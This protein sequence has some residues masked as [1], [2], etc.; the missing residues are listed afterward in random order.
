ML[1]ELAAH[2]GRALPE[3][4]ALP[5]LRSNGSLAQALLGVRNE[6]LPLIAEVKRASPS[7]GPLLRGPVGAYLAAVRRGGACAVSA[8]TA[9]GRFAGSF[10]LLREAHATGLP[11]LMKDFVTGPAQLDAAVRHGASAVL[12]IEG[13]VDGDGREG[14]VRAAHDRGLEVLLEVN[15]LAQDKKAAA[16][17]ADLLGVNSRDLAS[18]RVDLAAA[19]D[20]VRA[21]AQSRPTLLLSGVL[22][23]ADADHAREAGAAGILVATSL[24]SSRDPATLA[25]ALRRPLAKVCGNRTSADVLAAQ[26]A[27]LVGVV[28]ASDSPRSV[29][30]GAADPL[31]RQAESQGAAS[32][33]VTRE[34]R[35]GALL[36]LAR[37][38]RPT[39]VQVHGPLDP[40]T[41]RS[42]QEAEVGVLHAT[43][44]DGRPAPGCDG[45]VTDTASAGGSGRQ[46]DGRVP[47]GTGLHL[48]AGGLDAAS[49]PAA[50]R[51][52]GAAGVDASSRLETDGRKD[53]A[54]VHAF[55]AAAHAARRPHG[56]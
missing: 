32:V 6:G 33:V 25:R 43:A 29:E 51:R 46:H 14:L 54:K 20:V 42:L 30:A 36:A 15:S 26:G 41:V 5:A 50:L 2:A 38:L 45:T 11:T 7:A 21:L 52:S 13:L 19:A 10:G 12:L 40:A 48:V 31:L 35:P 39:Y 24:L 49:V 47:R 16:S 3:E 28:V 55:I 8:V 17:R 53:P 18:L 37:A 56:A 34:A 27:D 9:Q 23:P 44:P 1:R 22:G 4:A